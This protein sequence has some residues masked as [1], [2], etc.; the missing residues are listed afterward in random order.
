[1]FVRAY[2]CISPGLVEKYGSANWFRRIWR[3]FL[4]YMVDKLQ[5]KGIEDTK[6][7]DLDQCAYNFYL[8]GVFIGQVALYNEI[9]IKALNAGGC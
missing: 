1:M 4:D 2:Y 7:T 3:R 8:Q 9:R 6:Y 5:E